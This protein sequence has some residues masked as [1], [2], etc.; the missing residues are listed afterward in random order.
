[1]PCPATWKDQLVAEFVQLRTCG[2]AYEQITEPNGEASL[3]VSP[4]SLTC[5]KICLLRG[6]IFRRCGPDPSIHIGAFASRHLKSRPFGVIGAPPDAPAPL[7]PALVG[8][9]V[10]GGVGLA[11]AGGPVRTMV[12][13]TLW[14]NAPQ[15]PAM[16]V[17][18]TEGE[19]CGAGRAG[20]EG[21]AGGTAHRALHVGPVPTKTSN[22]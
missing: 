21:R 14:K 10:G 22:R 20:D 13:G 16:I 1:M 12:A 3:S 9:V 4:S 6:P 2:S 11:A 17:R 19:R 7:L 8:A 18:L 5:R 15:M